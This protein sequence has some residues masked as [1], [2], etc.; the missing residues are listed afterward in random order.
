MTTGLF[1]GIGSEKV[2][3]K[4]RT[5]SDVLHALR[6]LELD[7][8]NLD[9]YEPTFLIDFESVTIIPREEPLV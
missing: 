7:G 2:I 8:V 5:A 6:L 3:G 4:I 9:L 1:R